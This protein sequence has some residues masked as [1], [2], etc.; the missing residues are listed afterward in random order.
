[1]WEEVG[2][3]DVGR[4]GWVRCGKR[5]VEKMEAQYLFLVQSTHFHSPFIANWPQI[6]QYLNDLWL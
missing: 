5:F 1:M 6:T 4:G 2:G 3:L